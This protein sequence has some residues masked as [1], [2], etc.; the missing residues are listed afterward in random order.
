MFRNSPGVRR[1]LLVAL[2]IAGVLPSPASAQTQT[3]TIQGQVTDQ[4]GAVI[5]KAHLT[6]Q[7]VETGTGSTT[8]S[9]DTGSYAIPFLQPGYYN[10]SIEKAG[11][12]RLVRSGVKL[13]VGQTLGIDLTLRVGTVGQSVEITGGAPLLQTQDASVGHQIENKAIMTL[14]LNGRDYTQLVLLSPGAAPNYYSRASNGFSLNGGVTLQTTMLLSGMDNTNYQT[15]LDSGNINVLNPS[16]DAI[17]EFTVEAANYS[18]QYTRAANGVV[19]VSLKSGSNQ[20]HGSAFE[21]MRNDALDAN[22][23]FANRNGLRRP[24]L[25][26]NHFGATLGGP[27]L[28]NRSFFF[29]SCLGQRERTSGSGATTVPTPAMVGGNFASARIFN[30]FAVVNG[31]RQP[32][33]GNVIPANLMDP[34]GR[35]LATLYPAPKLPVAV[36]NYPYNR[37]NSF[38]QDQFDSRFDQQFSKSDSAFLA[39]SRGVGVRKQGS[40]FGPPGNGSPLPTFTPVRGYMVTIAETHI[41]SPSF[42]NDLHMGYTHMESDQTSPAKEPLFDQFGIVGV[43]PSRGLVGLPNIGVSGFS[44]LGDGNWHPNE[45]LAQ[46][47]QVND[48]ASLVR[49]KHTIRF[50][51][52]FLVIHNAGTAGPATNGSFSFNGQFTSQTPGIGSGSAFADL[53]LG[54]TSSAGLST[55]KLERLRNWALGL[56]VDDSWMATRKLTVNLGL[57]YDLQTPWVQ[58]DNT[59]ANFD[60][61]V[62]SPGYGTLVPAR[63]GSYLARAFQRLNTRNFAPRLGLAY[64]LTPKTVIRSAFGIFYGTY[65]YIAQQGASNLPYLVRVSLPSPTTAALTS[66]VLANG[67]PPGFASPERVQNAM[68]YGFSPDYPWPRVSQWNLTVQRELAAQSTFTVAYVGS[69]T[70]HLAGLNNINSPPPGPGAINPRRPFP[71]FGDIEYATPYAHS[72]YH[73]LQVTWAKRLTHGLSMHAAYTWSKALNNAVN[74]EDQ[75]SLLSQQPYPQ[76]P[77]NFAAEK[78]R[79]T[80]DIPQRFVTNF[81]YQPPLGQPGKFLGRSP[82]TRAIVRGWQ[83]GGILVAQTGAGLTPL[84]SPNPANTATSERPNRA[85]NGNLPGGGTVTRWYDVSCFATPAPFTYGNSGRL[86]ISAPGM[87]N[88]DAMIART[89]SVVEGKQLEFRTEFFNFTNT[90]HFGTPGMTVTLPTAGT[91]TSVL[92]PSRQLQL[93]LRLTF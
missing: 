89:F 18:A 85:C 22:D 58:R 63:D 41:F 54:Q 80:Y 91:I 81:I 11:F 7:N 40:I 64:R 21:F 44:A 82:V 55:I 36:N 24:P 65:G 75:G 47:I 14:P 68:A 9:N 84:V 67:F 23:F 3:G 4:T 35:K 76:D 8:E 50:G 93:A 13:A 16:V 42:V 17:Q 37:K 52:Q 25:R 53:L 34:V 29:L 20:F 61:T 83:L 78:S 73:A 15:G 74:H 46:T 19:S 39:Y 5:P 45:K 66:L 72:T 10:I 43:P 59:A 1:L 86:V 57:R 6:A 38:T 48:M 27:I 28:R 62:G 60:Y 12:E 70:S 77:N 79:A 51:G 90:A 88:L 30:P 71:R 32:F 69:S 87:L 31:A 26:R 56:F 49:G 2:A 92:S 33:P